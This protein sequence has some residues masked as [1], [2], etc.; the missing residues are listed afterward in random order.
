M[1]QCIFGGGGKREPG[2]NDHIHSL[3]HLRKRLQR[4]NIHIYNSEHERY[5]TRIH[6]DINKGTV[7]ELVSTSNI[8]YQNKPILTTLESSDIGRFLIIQCPV[9][10]RDASRARVATVILLAHNDIAFTAKHLVLDIDL[11]KAHI[12][13][14]FS[15]LVAGLGEKS[16][17]QYLWSFEP[18]V[19][20][21][22]PPDNDHGHWT[23]IDE[24]RPIHARR[25]RRSRLSAARP[26]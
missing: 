4:V 7:S 5:Y 17:Y 10:F 12:L 24:N 21:D 3:D 15:R 22:E 14:N 25:T 2:G 9:L 20:T 26:A 11:V 23:S 1:V 18:F 13:A 16:G 6:P 8:S 19:R